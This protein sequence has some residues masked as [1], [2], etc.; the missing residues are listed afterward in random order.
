VFKLNTRF[1]HPSA[2]GWWLAI[3]LICCTATPL[4]CQETTETRSV[5]VNTL[6]GTQQTASG[7]LTFRPILTDSPRATLKSF[8]RLRDA[9]EQTLNAYR[10]NRSM[11]LAE[12][13]QVISFQF[14]ALL[15]LSSVPPSLLHQVGTQ[16]N[17][18][19]LDILG[20]IELPNLESVPGEEAFDKICHL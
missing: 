4:H 11:E 3:V 6:S 18:Y 14:H 12:K 16:T 13:V 2:L 8:L 20:R 9:L 15:D 1:D 5:E 19:L 7:K 10:L 17:A